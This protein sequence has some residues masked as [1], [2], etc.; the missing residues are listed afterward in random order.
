MKKL[1]LDYS[2]AL[3]FIDESEITC[4]SPFIKKA[5]EMLHNKTGPGAT[6]QDGST[7]QKV[8]DRDEFARIKQRLKE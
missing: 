2:N 8:Y 1:G 3:A 7:C 4:L 5:H 6:S